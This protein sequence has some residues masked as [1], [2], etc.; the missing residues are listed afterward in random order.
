MFNQKATP[1]N[2]ATTFSPRTFGRVTL[3]IKTNRVMILYLTA[4]IFC[5]GSFIIM[6]GI[7]N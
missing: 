6:Q 4:N 7:T 3:S 5:T 2:G 1:K